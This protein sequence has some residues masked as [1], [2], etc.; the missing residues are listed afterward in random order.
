MIVEEEDITDRT[1][2]VGIGKRLL[3]CISARMTA[4][5]REALQIDDVVFEAKL[6]SEPSSAIGAKIFV[7]KKMLLGK[8]ETSKLKLME[9]EVEANDYS[10]LWWKTFL[11]SYLEVNAD[12]ERHKYFEMWF[13]FAGIGSV[14]ELDIKLAVEGF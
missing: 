7:L 2:Y 12:K 5:E 13:P 10:T 3:A 11:K 8:Y 9:N 14:A 6:V 4:S 1:D